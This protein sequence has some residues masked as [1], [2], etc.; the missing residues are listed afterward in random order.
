M[1]FEL[2]HV[3]GVRCTLVEPR[4]LKL[5]KQQRRQ[6]AAAQRA[7][8]IHTVTAAQ[9]E[10]PAPA[11]A[12]AQAQHHPEPRP[13]PQPQAG[14]ASQAAGPAAAP[15]AAG[16]NVGACSGAGGGG[17]GGGG[18]DGTPPL[19]LHQVQAF[20]GP[21]LWRSPGWRQRFVAGFSL[22][23]A[24]HP[25]QA[26]DPAL[27][28]ALEAA[29]PFAIVPCCVFPRLFPH[30]R[31]LR[32][33]GACSS[34]SSFGGNSIGDRS[35]SNGT[36]SSGGDSSSSAGN[37][38]SG[39]SGSGGAASVPVLTYS[40]LVEYLAARGGAQQAV[41]GFEGANTVVYRRQ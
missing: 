29:L 13:Q 8:T 6:L 10:A 38:G 37:G 26:T 35:G 4:P 25:D 9:L 20:F 16:T 36:S 27:D 1:T 28:Y 2:S 41:L 30:R 14:L 33:G 22:V 17:G 5:N 40:D 15:A 7:A 34:H 21:E 12:Q 18:A 31:L 39:S 11:Q 23:V 32:G 24:C 19:L 3:H